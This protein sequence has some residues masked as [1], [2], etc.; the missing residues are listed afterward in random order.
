M[1][2]NIQRA[3][4]SSITDSINGGSLRAG[5]MSEGSCQAIFQ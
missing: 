3:N 5:E 2:P 4:E 1:P